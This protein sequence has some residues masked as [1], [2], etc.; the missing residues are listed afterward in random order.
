MLLVGI[1][2]C[3][4]VRLEVGIGADES[5]VGIGADESSLWI[6]RSCL[7]GRQLWAL[8]NLW[9]GRLNASLAMNSPF[10]PFL[11]LHL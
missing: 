10:W 4:E 11:P 8:A 3:P 1:R 7:L 5:S 9:P 2:D 6:V